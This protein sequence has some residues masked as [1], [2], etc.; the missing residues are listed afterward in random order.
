MTHLVRCCAGESYVRENGMNKTAEGA[1]VPSWAVQC[2]DCYRVLAVVDGPRQE[3][4][5]DL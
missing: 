5:A 1:W 3:V 2:A 4:Y